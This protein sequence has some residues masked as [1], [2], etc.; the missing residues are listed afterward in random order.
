MARQERERRLPTTDSVCECGHIL[1]YLLDV[2]PVGLLQSEDQGFNSRSRE[3]SL[4]Q[5]PNVLI[6]QAHSLCLC[7]EIHLW[8]EV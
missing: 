2:P 7:G 4:K 6:Q 1:S 8:M 5:R 3:E